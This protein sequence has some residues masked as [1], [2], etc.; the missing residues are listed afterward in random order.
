MARKRLGEI[1]LSAGVIDQGKL[2][3]ALVE[4][5][6]WGGPLGRVMVDMGIVSEEV[7]VQALSRQLNIPAVSLEG[8][9]ISES[10]LDT[11]PGEICEQYSCLP[12]NIEGKF[13][14]VAM[15]DPTNLSIIDELRIRTQ[16]NVRSY[17]AGPKQIERALARYHGRGPASIDGS[18]AGVD[19]SVR[20]GRFNTADVIDLERNAGNA[21]PAG[22]REINA[23][24]LRAQG[25]SLYKDPES[26]KNITVPPEIVNLQERIARLESLLARDEDVIRKLMALLIEKGVATRDEIVE[27][28]K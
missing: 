9:S 27:R 14:D 23:A 22:A 19:P 24:G 17:L 1:L 7:L 4:Q 21:Q 3:A 8:R 20:S 10:A 13:L 28:L 2:R 25:M 11:L 16:L 15:S 18:L 6:R 12:F 5:R 26:G